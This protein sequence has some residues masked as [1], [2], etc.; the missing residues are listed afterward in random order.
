MEYD[1]E[2]LK[3][4][5]KKDPD[6]FEIVRAAMINDVIE[7]ARPENREI[8]RAK[9]W[10]LQQDLDRINDPLERMNHMV[11]VFWSGVNDFV[12][13]TKSLNNTENVPIKQTTQCKVIDIKRKSE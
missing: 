7:R 13:V 12:K 5:Y 11:S 2:Y 10:R 4:L 1:F 9:Q 6:E 8:L 3:D